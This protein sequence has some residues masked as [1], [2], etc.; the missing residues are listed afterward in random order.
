M[1]LPPELYIEK[2]TRRLKWDILHS[3]IVIVFLFHVAIFLILGYMTPGL[4]VP[5]MI[6]YDIGLVK[7]AGRKGGSRERSM[8]NKNGQKKKVLKKEKQVKVTKSTSVKKKKIPHTTNPKAML[9]QENYVKRRQV[10]ENKSVGDRGAVSSGTRPGSGG[11]S[12]QGAG[13]SDRGKGKGG[14]GYGVLI[15]YQF[16]LLPQ[17]YDSDSLQK[18]RRRYFNSEM[19]RPLLVRAPMPEKNSLLGI[20]HSKVRVKLSIPEIEN[21]PDVGIRPESVSIINIESNKTG[22]ADAH[23]QIVMEILNNSSWYPARREGRVI[24]EYI[25]FFVYVYGTEDG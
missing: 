11:R 20:G 9:P 18:E 16:N 25:T 12:E 4:P 19:S 17:R 1:P 14:S 24:Q 7:G 13:R 6:V 8:E 2:P 3:T 22:R 21:F 23:R 15:G 10:R 5:V